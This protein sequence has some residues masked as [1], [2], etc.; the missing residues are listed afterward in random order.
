[1]KKDNYKPEKE[2]QTPDDLLFREM[3]LLDRKLRTCEVY[4]KVLRDP[5]VEHILSGILHLEAAV[6]KYNSEEERFYLLDESYSTKVYED[7]PL[8]LKLKKWVEKSQSG[9]IGIENGLHRIGW[10]LFVMNQSIIK[11]L[12]KVINSARENFERNDLTD[13]GLQ[14][15]LNDSQTIKVK[16]GLEINLFKEPYHGFSPPKYINNL[17]DLFEVIKEIVTDNENWIQKREFFTRWINQLPNHRIIYNYEMKLRILYLF[18]WDFVINEPDGDIIEYLQKIDG[19]YYDHKY[20]EIFN[21]R[22]YIVEHP[23]KEFRYNFGFKDIETH[24]ERKNILDE[25]RLSMEID[26]IFTGIS[27]GSEKSYLEEIARQDEDLY[28]SVRVEYKEIISSIV[29]CFEKI[30][31]GQISNHDS[32]V[33]TLKN[34]IEKKKNSLWPK[35]RDIFKQSLPVHITTVLKLEKPADDGIEDILVAPIVL[36]DELLGLFMGHFTRPPHENERFKAF[37]DSILLDIAVPILMQRQREMVRDEILSRIS[38]ELRFPVTIFNGFLTGIERGTFGKIYDKGKKWLQK[39]FTSIN[40]LKILVDELIDAPK[41]KDNS[42][43]LNLQNVNL[44]DIFSQAESIVSAKAEEKQIRIIFKNTKSGLEVNVDKEKML[45]VVVNLLMNSIKFSKDKGEI[46]VRSFWES[47]C[48]KIEVEDTG[49]GISP[50]DINKIFDLRYQ[51]E[52][53]KYLPKEEGLGSSSGIGLFSVKRIVE[54][55]GGNISVESKIGEGTCFSFT[56]PK[57]K[58]KKNGQKNSINY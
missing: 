46:F 17:K 2:I 32:L 47:G 19:S 57:N 7:F 21:V 4:K 51:G 15:I 20:K 9:G 43:E 35:L 23:D 36:K 25:L 42:L 14:K 12:Y 33:S 56:I 45:R 49:I 31:D 5:L 1:M 52:N 48:L 13:E 8:N 44:N 11:S 30:L 34:D 55:H 29:S 54:L 27:R 16:N 26:F 40:Y 10:N 50:D 24:E 3:Q 18:I 39:S 6:F 37:L 28:N 41:L 53:T 22:E 58:E 38:H